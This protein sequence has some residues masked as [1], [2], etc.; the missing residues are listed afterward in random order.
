MLKVFAPAKVNLYLHVTGRQPDGYH[1]L[2]SL[3]TFADI[4]DSITFTKAREFSFTVDGPHAGSF[5][6]GELDTSPQSKNLV[7]K[8]AWQLSSLLARELDVA[9]HLTKNLPFGSGLGGGSADAAACMW[10]LCQF[11]NV[12]LPDGHRNSLAL[13][14]GRDVPVCIKSHTTF[15]RGT[16][17]YLFKAPELP[18]IPVVLAWPGEPVST[19]TVFGNLGMTSFS[20]PVQF[21]ADYDDPQSLSDFLALHTR[22]DLQPASCALNGVIHSALGRLAAQ[23]G[24]QLARM[25]G[26]GSACFGIFANE[27]QT[28]AAAE[29]LSLAHPGWWVRSGWLNRVSRY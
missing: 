23:P 24:C 18:E 1:T 28:H 5:V 14:L 9:I 29:T 27:D 6:R 3:V 20:D 16:G 15:M 8:A 26:S 17:E 7:V 2:D 25:S 21:A 12:P 4:G 19:A 11:W 13:Q 22:N 10:G